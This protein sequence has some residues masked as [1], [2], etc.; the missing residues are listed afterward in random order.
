MDIVHK[1]NIYVYQNKLNYIQKNAQTTEVIYY[2][3]W[4]LW[5]EYV[6]TN[7]MYANY[8]CKNIIILEFLGVHVMC[9][10]IVY[11]FDKLIL[12]YIVYI[13]VLDRCNMYMLWIVH[14]FFIT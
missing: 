7:S 8:V 1:Y 4:Q 10:N 2:M 5:K 9:A 3:T 6:C 13:Y 14:L 11:L 12:L